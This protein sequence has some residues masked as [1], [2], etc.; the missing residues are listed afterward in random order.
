MNANSLFVLRPYRYQGSWVFDDPAVGLEREPFVFGIDEMID[1]LVATIPDAESGFRLIFSPLVVH[2][3]PEHAELKK[4][5]RGCITRHHSHHYFGFSETQWKLFIKESPRRVRTPD[6]NDPVR[7]NPVMPWTQGKASSAGT[8]NPI[9]AR[10][11]IQVHDTLEQCGVKRGDKGKILAQ[12]RITKDEV[13]RCET[14]LAALKREWEP[15]GQR[16]KEGGIRRSGSA[17]ECP[18]VHDLERYAT[19]FVTSAKR[20]LQAAG[21]VYNEFYAPPKGGM[22]KNGNFNFAIKHLATQQPPNSDYLAFLNENEAAVQTLVGLRNGQEHPEEASRHPT[23]SSCPQSRRATRMKLRMKRAKPLRRGATGIDCRC[24]SCGA[25]VHFIPPR[26]LL[27]AGN[28]TCHRNSTDHVSDP[29]SFRVEQRSPC[30]AG[31]G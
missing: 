22:V 24:G 21:E 4:I 2:T 30:L 28:G 17:L 27:R 15:V 11:F 5:A 13:L 25:P 3:T 16:I 6:N 14:A 10:L 7:T 31:H 8:K 26:D 20:A 18:Q 1:R 23:A 9:V 12:M 19:Q 29:R